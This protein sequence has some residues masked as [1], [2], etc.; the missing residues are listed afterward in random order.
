METIAPGVTATG[1]EMAAWSRQ[2]TPAPMV[3]D[4]SRHPPGRKGKVMSAMEMRISLVSDM[5]RID[6]CNQY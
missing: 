6:T 2:V 4:W 3:S 5:V 1:P